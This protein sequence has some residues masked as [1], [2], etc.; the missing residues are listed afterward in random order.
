[1]PERTQEHQTDTT[2]PKTTTLQPDS[3]TTPMDSPATEQIAENLTSPPDPPNNFTP[4]PMDSSISLK[5]SHT[6]DS[7]SDN[8][9]HKPIPRRPRMAPK[10][11]ITVTR[12][13]ASPPYWKQLMAYKNTLTT[14]DSKMFK[15]LLF[16]LFITMCRLASVNTQGGNPTPRQYALRTL[17]NLTSQFALTDI[18]RLRKPHKSEFT[19]T[20]RDTRTHL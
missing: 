15:L 6:T 9:A 19:W 7:D 18:W 16:L 8:P 3:H 13:K 1:M 11:N 20:G 17:H 14:S 4:T 10:P 5:R 12:N 2:P